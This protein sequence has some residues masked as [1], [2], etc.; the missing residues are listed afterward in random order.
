MSAQHDKSLKLA[1][2]ATFDDRFSALNEL[3]YTED[4]Q[5]FLN[6]LDAINDPSTDEIYLAAQACWR[7]GRFQQAF[8]LYLKAASGGRFA[9]YY[10]AARVIREHG[11]SLK[12]DSSKDDTYHDLIISAAKQGHLW[13]RLKVLKGRRKDSIV[14][15]IRYYWLRFACSPFIIINALLISGDREKVRV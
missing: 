5:E 9:G 10:C 2:D 3:P 4:I 7:L 15:R 12:P 6:E 13:S 1:D 8:D 14:A 11:N